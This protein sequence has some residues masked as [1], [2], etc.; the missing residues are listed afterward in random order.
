M[1]SLF[2]LPLVAIS[3]IAFAGEKSAPVVTQQAVVVSSSDCASASRLGG[4]G[5]G[6]L[7]RRAERRE[8][9]VASR[10]C[11]CSAAT[12]TVCTEQPAI[13]RTESIYRTTKVG[14]KTTIV[15]AGAAQ[16]VQPKSGK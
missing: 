10:S 5:G 7:S 16:T 2:A 4:C 15:P 11:G 6:L 12:A 13:I 8:A 14:E 9:R 3:G 1:K